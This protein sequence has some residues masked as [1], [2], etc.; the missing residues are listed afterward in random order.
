[1]K[2]AFTTLITLLCTIAV[3]SQE[4][5]SVYS[6]IHY[7]DD[8]KLYFEINGRKIYE[9]HKPGGYELEDMKGSPGGTENGISFTFPENFTG[10]MYYGF[11]HY[12]DSKY[13]M[14]VYFRN[15]SEIS[16]GACEIDI[17]NQMSGKYD[18]IGWENAGT[19]TLGYR[20]L[21]EYGE[22]IYDGIVTFEG[23][24][25]F[26]IANTVIEGP[27]ISLL[28]GSGATITFRTNKKCKGKIL[29]NGKEFDEKKATLNHDIPVTGLLPDT[30]YEYTV[31]VGS[32][33]QKYS[34]RTAPEPGSRSSFSF[35]Y[36]SDSRNGQG[37]GERGFYGV[38]SYIMKKIMAASLHY[39]AR[40]MVFTG[41]LI[42]GY[43]TNKK[44]MDLQY[45]NWKR[46]VE[47]FAHY[48]PLYVGMGNHEALM[49]VF[50]D[51]VTAIPFSVDRIPFETESAE[52][53]FQDHFTLPLNGPDS[54]DGSEYDPNPDQIDFP[55]YKESVYYFTYD[56]LA[57]IVL[58]SD[59]WYAPSLP[60]YQYSSGNLHGYLMD[61][62]M[63]WLA[64]AL[65]VLEQDEN[66]DHVFVTQ[67][68]PAFP[69]GGHVADDMW[70]NGNNDY[71]PY[72]KGKPVKTGIIQ[73]RDEYLDLIINKSKKV[74]A[75]LT[76]DEH[77]YNRMQLTSEVNIY[78]ETYFHPKLE[79]TRSVWQINN[80][81]AGAPYYA[82]E[83]TPWSDS[84]EGF[85]TQNAVVIFH[86]NGKQ[87]SME[88]I[89][90]D[91]LEKIDELVLKE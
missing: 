54:E 75:L 76:G 19:G 79:I 35:S 8:G 50:Y 30:D 27:F 57:V 55:S 89:N 87:L 39:D 43:L 81:A 38:N 52:A 84:V 23:T 68:T 56:N 91:T 34:F 78:P 42:D 70:Y 77:N 66:I 73:R 40:F 24:G 63:E 51:S 36:A 26:K 48:I 16:G 17:K 64:E 33:D 12:Y 14:P 31:Q 41:D 60:F 22:M 86:V 80:G 67:H 20:V 69:N 5:P 21:N 62:Q 15:F 59:Y 9:S 47:A 4:V 61:M 88:V 2:T 18:M 46:S 11:I 90:P 10:A 3:F 37:G 85:T 29:V 71:R 13:P 72:V 65:G 7:D 82:Q 83:E 44:Q 32:V 6:Q 25:P 74:V 58:N 1:M 53:A 49:N 45:S 28:S